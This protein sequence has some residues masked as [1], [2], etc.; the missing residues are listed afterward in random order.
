MAA[1]FQLRASSCER[2]VISYELLLRRAL[3]GALAS[4]DQSGAQGPQATPGGMGGVP[5]A[6]SL[7]N[8]AEQRDSDAQ[9]RP[10]LFAGS[11]RDR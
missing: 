3:A 11:S 6:H 7:T 9:R 4:A 5:P 2:S 1:S 8:G 10:V